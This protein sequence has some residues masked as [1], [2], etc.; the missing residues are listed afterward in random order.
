MQKRLPKIR[1]SLSLPFSLTLPLSLSRARSLPPP[2]CATYV[3]VSFCTAM[4]LCVM[5]FAIS[6]EASA[7]P[8]QVQI[9][10]STPISTFILSIYQC[11]DFYFYFYFYF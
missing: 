5:I 10:E 9:L 1:L 7:S 6:R 2:T 3:L 4:V 8:L 11:T